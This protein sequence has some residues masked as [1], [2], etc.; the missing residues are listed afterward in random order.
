MKYVAYYWMVQMTT[1]KPSRFDNVLDEF[2][3]DIIALAMSARDEKKPFAHY[4]A[5]L[6]AIRA[7]AVEK[8]EEIVNA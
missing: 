1:S 5:E 4:A 8:L 2:G 7:R 3:T 6:L